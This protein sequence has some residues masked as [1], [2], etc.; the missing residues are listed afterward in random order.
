MNYPQFYDKISRK[1]LMTYL[2]KED[3]NEHIT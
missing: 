2:I 1:D 3:T